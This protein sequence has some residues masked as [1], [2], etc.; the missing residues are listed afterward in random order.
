MKRLIF[1]ALTLIVGVGGAFAS[2]RLSAAKKTATSY[3]YYLENACDTPVVCDSN[4]EGPVCAEQFS[5]VVVYDAP[6]CLNGHEA[7]VI[8]GKLPLQ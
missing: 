8:L 7:A 5:G 1:F 4:N 6:F 3:T 2:T